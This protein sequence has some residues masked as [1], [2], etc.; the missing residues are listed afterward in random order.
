MNLCFELLPEA[1]KISCMEEMNN[2][3]ISEIY[4]LF[5]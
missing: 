4:E 3:K 2:Q 5:V 1:Q